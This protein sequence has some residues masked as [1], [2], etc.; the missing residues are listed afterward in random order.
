MRKRTSTTKKKR[1]RRRIWNG[2]ADARNPSPVARPSSLPS[3]ANETA[4][5]KLA[6]QHATGQRATHAAGQ[7]AGQRA[8][9][10]RA[11]H[12]T[13][14]PQG[15]AL[16][17]TISLQAARGASYI[18]GPSLAGGLRHAGLRHADLW[19]AGLR[20]ADLWHASLRH[21]GLLA[22]HLFHWPDSSH[23][24]MAATTE[25]CRLSVQTE[26]R[27]KIAVQPRT[28][29]VSSRALLKTVL[30]VKAL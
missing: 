26:A 23:A 22:T 27:S 13:G 9:G 10:L 25:A 21:A 15:M 17:Y 1:R 28:T 7:H 4:A 18:V 6:G 24:Q 12:A 30:F 16:L 14:H 3:A 19:H 2:D 11:T 20:H 5:I 8:I 29:M